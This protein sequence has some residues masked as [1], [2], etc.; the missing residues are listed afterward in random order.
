M[1]PRVSGCALGD[2]ASA[3]AMTHTARVSLEDEACQVL[4]VNLCGDGQSLRVFPTWTFTKT[5]ILKTNQWVR[6]NNTPKPP[7]VTMV[8]DWLCGEDCSPT[9]TCVIGYM[10]S[11]HMHRLCCGKAGLRA[12]MTSFASRCDSVQPAL[13]NDCSAPHPS[14]FLNPYKCTTSQSMLTKENLLRLS[15]DILINDPI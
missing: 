8:T 3:L 7:R 14:V 12:A 4:H 11:E 1:K 2:D 6:L 10:T 5:F 13:Q 9:L 15:N